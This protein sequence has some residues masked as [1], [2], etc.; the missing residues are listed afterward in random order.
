MPF[1]EDLQEKASVCTRHM[2]HLLILAFVAV[3]KKKKESCKKILSGEKEDEK[4]YEVMGNVLSLCS[5][6]AHHQ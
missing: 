3:L 2:L 4:V 5:Y 1:A 6:Q